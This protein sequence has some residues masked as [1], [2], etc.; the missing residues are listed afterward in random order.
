MTKYQQFVERYFTRRKSNYLVNK[1]EK[2]RSLIPENKR[3]E[4][5]DFEHA[6]FTCTN[7][8]RLFETLTPDLI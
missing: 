1:S 7:E 3:D 2:W 6:T 8:C 4:M 5:D